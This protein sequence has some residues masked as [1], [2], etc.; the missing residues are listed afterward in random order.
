MMCPKLRAEPWTI[1]LDSELSTGRVRR[2]CELVH[3]AC[4]AVLLKVS[5]P[6]FQAPCFQAPK[7][8][9]V[10][11]HLRSARAV[12][13]AVFQLR[14]ILDVAMTITFALQRYLLMVTAGSPH[15]ASQ[16]HGSCT[17]CLCAHTLEDQESVMV[18]WCSLVS[19]LWRATLYRL[20]C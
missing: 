1:S 3:S 6:C 20:I 5:V 7:L 9:Q 17:P 15:G 2:G 16:Q 18:L 8:S 19:C 14:E 11:T 4:C 12:P 10:Q 13:S